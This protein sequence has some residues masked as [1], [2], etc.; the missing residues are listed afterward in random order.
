MRVLVTGSSGFLGRH[1]CKALREAGR[2]PF[3][4]LHADYDL[5]DPS[6]V[7]RLYQDSNPDVVIHLAAEV[8]GIGANQ[9]NPGRYFYANMAMGL[10]MIEWA[11]RYEV[12]KFV[13]VGT[14]CAYPCNTPVPFSEDDLHNGYPEPTNAPYG[15]AKRALWTMLDAYRRQYDLHSVY[16]LLAN[17]YGPGDNYDPAS[18]HVIPAIIRKVDEAMKAGEDTVTLWGTGTP[19]REFLYV[20]DA[21]RAIVQAALHW[22]ITDPINIGADYKHAIRIC[23]LAD[24]IRK[25]MGYEGRV[26]WDDT[27][28]D[29]QP[30]RCLSTLRA[31][32][33]GFRAETALS[34]GLAETIKQWRASRAV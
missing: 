15:I 18:S 22:D 27:K 17:L 32:A 23:R 8:G 16:L 20:K 34:D 31:E 25:A 11:R 26:V 3:E 29:G 1:V 28:P 30:R 19:T 4:A 10:N 5:T 12:K 33:L 7:E 21:A 2:T 13:Q 9:A 24:K 6:D 14:V